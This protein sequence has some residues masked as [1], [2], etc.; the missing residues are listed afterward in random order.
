MISKKLPTT[1]ATHP[2]ATRVEIRNP[3]H[4]MT[5]DTRRIQCK[6]AKVIAQHDCPVCAQRT[7]PPCVG[8]GR[9][10][11][12]CPLKLKRPGTTSRSRSWSAA[13]VQRNYHKDGH[14]NPEPCRQF[15][16]D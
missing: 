6:L 12:P 5:A 7:G 8:C 9:V 3:V 2:I 10:T 13:C 4:S 14:Q 11:G 1:I 16:S 15:S